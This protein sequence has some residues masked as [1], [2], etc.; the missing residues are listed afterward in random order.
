MPRFSASDTRRLR[1]IARELGTIRESSLTA[2]AWLAP[3]LR[4][5]LRTEKAVTCTYAPRAD[6]LSIVRGGESK[7][8]TEIHAFTDEWLRTAP[9]RWTSFNPMRPEPAHR[10]RAMTL[11]DIQRVS[12]LASPPVVSAVYAK[13][14]LARDDTLRVLVCDGASLVGYVALFQA[15]PFEKRQKRLLSHLVPAIQQRLS[16][17]RLLSH[18]SSTKLLLGAALEEIPSAAFVLSDGGRVIET[19]RLGARWLDAKGLDGRRALR[20][21]VVAP[22][23]TATASFRLTRVVTAEESPKVLAVELT[24]MAT[25]YAVA[26]A[27][28]RWGFTARELQVLE[29]VADGV[30]TRTLAAH[31]A[32]SERTVEAHLT[33]MFAK[34]QVATRAEMIA[35]AM[36]G[37]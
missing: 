17:E 1:E 13:Y 26:R 15:N 23:P 14:G 36:S 24:T 16:R 4:E 19:N 35:K 7:L 34:A 37:R 21:A 12:G 28:D 20:D 25:F 32:V 2:L 3:T 18:A 6:G 22:A 11:D 29:G 5:V 33:R 27:G 9:V 8:P 31:L 10:N 30:P